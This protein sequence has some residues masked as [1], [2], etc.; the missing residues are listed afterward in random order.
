MIAVYKRT[1]VLILPYIIAASNL[2]TPQ[3][4]VLWQSFLLRSH[5][6]TRFSIKEGISLEL[7]RCV[8]SPKKKNQRI[9]SL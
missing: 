5:H 4:T 2:R 3:R 1:N 9:I 6:L 7:T 8:E